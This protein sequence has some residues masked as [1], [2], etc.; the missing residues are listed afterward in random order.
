MLVM[1]GCFLVGVFVLGLGA[2]TLIAVPVLSLLKVQQKGR[3]VVGVLLSCIAVLIASYFW[4][5][6]PAA[7]FEMHFGFAPTS[8][9]DGLV[10]SE[11]SIFADSGRSRL[12]FTADTSTVDRIVREQFGLKLADSS[13]EKKGFHHFQR[14]FSENFSSETQDLKFDPDSGLVSFVWTGV[15]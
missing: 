11:H 10:V 4:W 12:R 8:D 15:D 2:I 5:T 1:N 7:V 13:V 6:R 3:W 14:F 9:V